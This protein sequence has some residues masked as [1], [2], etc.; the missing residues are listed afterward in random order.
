[1]PNAT[2][3]TSEALPSPQLA[4]LEASPQSDVL[5]ALSHQ[6]N[7]PDSDISGTVDERA[8]D[9]DQAKQKLM[10]MVESFA[11]EHGFEAALVMA[12]SSLN[13]NASLTL[14][15]TTAGATDFFRVRCCM[16]DDQMTSNFKTHIY[17]RHSFHT[18][19]RAFGS[20]I[21]EEHTAPGNEADHSRK[22]AHTAGLGK[23]T[24]DINLIRKLISA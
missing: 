9:F 13:R 23:A 16:D 5:V 20:N 11:K 4:G 1:M 14:V 22:D 24:D 8:Q 6:Q 15:H 21:A 7:T 12:G 10:S 18:I 3:P 19:A 2:S 17:N